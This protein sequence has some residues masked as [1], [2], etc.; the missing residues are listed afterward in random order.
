MTRGFAAALSTTA[1]VSERSKNS[2]LTALRLLTSITS[3][4]ALFKEF[5]EFIR[6]RKKFWLLP[7]CVVLALL[8]VVMVFAEGS[9]IAPFIYS[10]F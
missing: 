8:A 7:I 6:I 2:G 10:F 5:G 9:A 1:S 3:M 4:L